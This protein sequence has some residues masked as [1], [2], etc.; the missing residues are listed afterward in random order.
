MSWPVGDGS[1]KNESRRKHYRKVE[2]I[3]TFNFALTV[4][5]VVH[6]FQMDTTSPNS[7]YFRFEKHRRT[8]SPVNLSLIH[9]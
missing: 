3:R 9:I 2:L 6:G 4:F 8:I 5:F 7:A 1:T